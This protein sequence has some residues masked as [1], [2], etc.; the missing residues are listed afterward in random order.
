MSDTTVRSNPTSRTN[1]YNFSGLEVTVN[2]TAPASGQQFDQLV[3][4]MMKTV[5][6]LHGAVAELPTDPA[7][8]PH[9][10]TVTLA[11]TAKSYYLPAGELKVDVIVKVRRVV[12]LHELYSLMDAVLAGSTDLVRIMLAKDA[13]DMSFMAAVYEAAKAFSPKEMDTDPHGRVTRDAIAGW[14]YANQHNP[15]AHKHRLPGSNTFL[16]RV[17]G[18]ALPPGAAFRTATATADD[19]VIRHYPATHDSGSHEVPGLS[20]YYRA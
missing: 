4:E 15:G 6:V 17:D 1:R 13:P 16:R 5:T 3:L 8:H 20:S 7:G 14:A 19:S 9:G 12:D 11:Q 10:N 2:I 18:D